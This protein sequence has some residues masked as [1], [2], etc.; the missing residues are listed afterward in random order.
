MALLTPRPPV[1]HPAPPDLQEAV[2]KARSTWDGDF[3]NLAV[4]YAARQTALLTE[5]MKNRPVPLVTGFS[6]PREVHEAV[7]VWR[8]VSEDLKQGGERKQGEERARQVFKDAGF[9]D[10]S[11][12]SP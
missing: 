6:T 1:W 10:Y 2:V 12:A 4:G 9:L 8:E 5:Q 11:W 7:K 3:P